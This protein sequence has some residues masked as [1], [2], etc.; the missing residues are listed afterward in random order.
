MNRKYATPA[1]YRE[2]LNIKLGGEERAIKKQT[3]N[4]Q[5]EKVYFIIIN[6]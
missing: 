2:K 5:M 3:Y 4:E 1:Q 6:L